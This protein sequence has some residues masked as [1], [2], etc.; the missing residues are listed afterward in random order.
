MQN[1]ILSLIF[2]NDNI[3][4]FDFDVEPALP[5]RITS[6]K[7]GFEVAGFGQDG[8]YRILSRKTGQ[9]VDIAPK[10]LDKATLFAHIG[11]DY[12]TRHFTKPDPETGGR[13][14][15]LNRVIFQIRQEC[16]NFGPANL[17]DV[18]GPGLYLDDSGLVVNY[19]DAVFDQADNP[20]STK[21]TPTRAYV[22]G[23][24]L[25][26][27]RE[28]PCA[29]ADEV[30]AV[31]QAFRS[32]A[33]E[34]NWGDAASL[35]WFASSVLGAVLPNSPSIILTAEKGAGKSTWVSLQVALLGQQAILRDGV[36]SAPQVLHAVSEKS[37]T[38]ICDE[39]EPLKRSKAQLESLTE[40]FN[41]GFTKSTGKG[42][43]TR[44]SGKSLRYFNPPSGVALCGINVPKLDDALE[45]RSVRLSMVRKDRASESKC[46][47][48]NT[49]NGEA[50]L[51]GAR[52]RRL[53]VSRWQVVRDTRA[54]VHEML[55]SIGHSDRFADTYSPLVAGYIGLKHAAVPERHVLEELLAQWSLNEVRVDELDTPSEACL[56]TLLDRKVVIKV[57]EGDSLAKTHMRLRDAI[58]M[59][60]GRKGDQQRKEIAYQLELLG[61]RPLHDE[62]GGAWRMAVAA[63]QHH[64]EMR[65]LTTGTPWARGAWKDALLR[66]PGSAKGQARLAGES[67]KVVIVR[68]PDSVMNPLASD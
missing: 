30:E 28:T 27:S 32:F 45:S 6:S 66:L 29:T 64:R 1:K 49:A 7:G 23:Q 4:S 47:L 11:Q 50:R 25:G 67:V 44:V 19:G 24:G 57:R 68:L 38:L 34:Q 5:G 26:F 63:S 31:E 8:K 42:K 37:V 55:Q 35:G 2:R 15:D 58:H 20:V 22:S 51:L 48:L 16:D 56:S 10:Q 43:F 54:Q 13:E 21:P 40:V 59:M 12:C 17:E 39:F 3:S 33:F 62:G 60:A 18:R 46:R 52:L 41:S 65:L 53:L 14:F 61:I 36:P 9:L